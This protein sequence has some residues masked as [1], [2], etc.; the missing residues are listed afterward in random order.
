MVDV[1]NFIG[2]LATFGFV[3]VVVVLGLFLAWRDDKNKFR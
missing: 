1:I 3:G 2:G